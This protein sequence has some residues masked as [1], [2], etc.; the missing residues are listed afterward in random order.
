[1]AERKKRRAK[2]AA[3]K[4]AKTEEVKLKV[5]QEWSRL[6]SENESLA[7]KRGKRPLTDDQLADEMERLFPEKAGKTTI[8]RVSMARSCYN[9]G[10]NM[11]ASMGPAGTADRPVSYAYDEDG[12]QIPPR[13]NSTAGGGVKKKAAKKSAPK[14]AAK[15]A[16]AKK[17][18]RRRKVSPK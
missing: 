15:K 13:G 17:S 9:K 6:L 5:N 3:P 16:T 1:M 8:T 10:T 11:F 2:K 14:K 7:T 4:K 12:K 18:S